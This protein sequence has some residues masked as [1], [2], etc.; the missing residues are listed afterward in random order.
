M[1]VDSH[2]ARNWVG[3]EDR[4]LRRVHPVPSR[5]CSNTI[6]AGRHSQLVMARVLLCGHASVLIHKVDALVGETHALPVLRDLN[7][8]CA[9]IV[10][11]RV[12]L[13]LGHPSAHLVVLFLLDAL[14]CL[15]VYELLPGVACAS[16]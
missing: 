9:L 15:R 1:V 14:K 4:W 2:G 13:V 10:L 8:A 3:H 7:R 5:G 16:S 11:A 12:D 6:T